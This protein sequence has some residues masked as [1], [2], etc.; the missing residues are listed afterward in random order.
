MQQGV[1]LRNL[2]LKIR[3]LNGEPI[4]LRVDIRPVPFEDSNAAMA[5]L[6]RA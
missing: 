1:E 5:T 3:A 4:V 6:A 2:A